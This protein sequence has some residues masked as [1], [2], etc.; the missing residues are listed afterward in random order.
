MTG[1]YNKHV[2]VRAVTGF[3]FGPFGAPSNMLSVMKLP[4]KLVKFRAI[5]GVSKAIAPLAWLIIQGP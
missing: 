4:T 3:P 5:R 2:T 1:V